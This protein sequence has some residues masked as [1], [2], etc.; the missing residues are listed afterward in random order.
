MECKEYV[1]K[2]LDENFVEFMK[3]PVGKNTSYVVKQM[4]QDKDVRKKEFIKI[5]QS[6]FLASAIMQMNGKKPNKKNLLKVGCSPLFN[7][8]YDELCETVDESY[9]QLIDNL[10]FL[11]RLT[12]DHLVS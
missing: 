8:M 5:Y 10:P 6:I 11:D 1:M 4:Y 3:G 9:K 7:N 2:G 12:F